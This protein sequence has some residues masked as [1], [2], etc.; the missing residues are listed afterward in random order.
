M[1]ALFV[2]QSPD[3]NSDIDNTYASAGA[4]SAC[5]PLHAVE[6]HQHAITNEQSDP[7][8]HVASAR[9]L[10]RQKDECDCSTN[11]TRHCH[12][13]TFQLIEFQSESG[14]GF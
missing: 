1:F 9:R 5:I 10:V 11:T 12:L 4:S 3:T 8:E 7:H 2:T 13:T 14:R 6:T